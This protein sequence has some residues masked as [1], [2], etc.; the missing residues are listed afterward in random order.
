MQ[1]NLQKRRGFTLVELMSVLAIL[2]L[3]M[4]FAIPAYTEYDHRVRRTK[5]QGTLLDV[6]GKM[7]EAYSTKQSFNDTHTGGVP[8][9]TF[10]TSQSGQDYNLTMVTTATTYT[11]TATPI[12]GGHQEDDGTITITRAGVRTWDGNA[13]W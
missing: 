1:T 5:V 9:T 8:N 2:G 3:I 4:A 13:G 7:E 11:L 12:T 10:Y 6:S